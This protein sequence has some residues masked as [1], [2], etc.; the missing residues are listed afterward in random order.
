ML[1]RVLSS[2]RGMDCGVG[3]II[4]KLFFLCETL[5]VCGPLH[6]CTRH[7]SR[8]KGVQGSEAVNVDFV[9]ATGSAKRSASAAAS[10]SAKKKSKNSK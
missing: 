9:V 2:A 6:T 3:V 7:F 1:F 8:G 4:I 10:C 5:C